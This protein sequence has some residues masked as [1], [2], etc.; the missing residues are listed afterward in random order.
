M[1]LYSVNHV[2][3]RDESVRRAEEMFHQ[4]DNDGNGDLTEVRY[5]IKREKCLVINVILFYDE[6][7]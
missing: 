5:G 2:F 4:L 1:E 3:I 6:F 7:L